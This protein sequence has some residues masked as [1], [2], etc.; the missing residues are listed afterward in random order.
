MSLRSTTAYLFRFSQCLNERSNL[1]ASPPQARMH[2]AF[3]NLEEFGD[4]DSREAFD[5]VEDEGLAKIGLQGFEDAVTEFDES[6]LV[7]EHVGCEVRRGMSLDGVL[8]DLSPC[9]APRGAREADG[10]PV[11]ERS[12]ASGTNVVEFRRCDEVKLL[13][14]VLE[15]ILSN[16]EASEHSPSEALGLVEETAESESALLGPSGLGP[17]ALR[18]RATPR[19]QHYE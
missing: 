10:N 4:L 15:P 11:D 7:D 12:L 5:F 13:E 18:R 1:G 19:K 3:R 8:G 17:R 9:F 2:R 6:P 14:A 16:P